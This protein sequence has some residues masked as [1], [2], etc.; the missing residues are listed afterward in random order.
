[1]NKKNEWNPNG[2]D[3]EVMRAAINK[4]SQSM[5]VPDPIPYAERVA[6][7]LENKIKRWESSK[8]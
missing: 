7:G 3:S 4:L 6:K 5:H 8:L 2:K 1:M